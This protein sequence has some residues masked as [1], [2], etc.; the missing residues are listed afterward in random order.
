MRK[1]IVMRYPKQ[2]LQHRYTAEDLYTWAAAAWWR[3]RRHLSW[4][5]ESHVV[6]KVTR[7]TC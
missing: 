2:P 6:A 7:V 5:F 1:P 3:R 4:V